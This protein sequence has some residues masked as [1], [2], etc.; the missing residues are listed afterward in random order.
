MPTLQELRA[1]GVA[2]LQLPHAL[3]RPECGSIRSLVR[4]LIRTETLAHAD[5]GAPA[6][7]NREP[8]AA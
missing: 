2:T 7:A 8:M 4:E 3:P 6:G 1:V 5:A